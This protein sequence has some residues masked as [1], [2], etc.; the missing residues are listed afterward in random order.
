MDFSEELRNILKKYIKNYNYDSLIE[1]INNGKTENMNEKELYE[2]ISLTTIS[3]VGK[4]PDFD[5]VASYYLLKKLYLNINIYD[6]KIVLDEII[7][8]SV[9]SEKYINYCMENMNFINSILNFDNDY[10]INYFGLKTLEN[11]YLLKSKTGSI[12]ETPQ[13]LFL[14]VS[15]GI[16]LEKINNENIKKSYDVFS[17]LYYTHATPTLYNSGSK[18][19]QLSSCYLM[20]CGDSIDEISKTWADIAK[21][22]KWAGGIGINISD[23][24][25]YGSKIK[26]NNGHSDGIIPL[27]K[28]IESIGKY[29][30]QCFSPETMV[31]GLFGVK[32]I[33]N[34]EIG[35]YV[36]TIDSSFK[37]VNNIYKKNINKEILKISTIYS[38]EEIL[39]TKE[40][41]IYAFNEDD[42]IPCY[43]SANE[44]TSSHKLCYCICDN[45]YSD[46]DDMIEYYKFYGTIYANGDI[47]E[48]ENTILIIYKEFMPIIM[49][50][51]NFLIKE[52]INYSLIGYTFNIVLS[53]I[54]KKYLRRIYNSGNCKYIDTEFFN[55]SKRDTKE[56]LNGIFESSDKYFIT[57]NRIL[58]YQIAYL[59]LKYN[60]PRRCIKEN[61]LYK[62]ECICNKSLY[63][64]YEHEDDEELNLLFE[65]KI[66]FDIENIDLIDYNG[67][68]YDLNIEDNHNYTT[69]LGLVHNSGKRNGSIAIYIEPWHSDIFYFCD[70][71]RITGDESMRTR[72]LFLGLWIPDMFMR[73]VQNDDYWYLMCPDTC[74]GLT[75]SYGEEFDKL[76][77]GYVKENKYIKKVKA[78]DLYQKILESQFETGMP[79]ML[80]KD[81]CNKKS[82]QK[83][84]GTIKNSNLCSE[85]LEY[86]SKDE[87]SVCNLASISLPKFIVNGE[88]DFNK[89]GEIVRLATY[90]LN[91]VIDINF[92]PI[93]ETETSNFKHRPIGLGVQGLSD[94]FQLL[95]Y[96]FDSIEASN[97]NKKIFECI[98]YNSLLE[99]NEIAKLDGHYSSFD[100]SPFSK[101]LLQF[102]LWDKNIDDLHIDNY[103]DF[104]W[105]SLI[106]N[107]KIYGTRNSLLTTVMPTASTSL[108]MGNCECIEPYTSNMYM[109]KTGKSAFLVI[110]NNLVNDLKNINLWDDMMYDKLKKNDGSIQ[111]ISEIPI[112]IRNIYKTAFEITQKTIV[113]LSIGRAPFIDHTQ[114]LNIFMP[115]PN[116]KKLSNAHFYGWKYGLKT[117]MYYLRSKPASKNKNNEDSI[118]VCKYNGKNKGECETCSA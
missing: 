87:T 88:F 86:S 81:S 3:Y 7:K 65:N 80:Y 30:N 114:S 74:R 57:E 79:Y 49:F 31:Y 56:F 67:D 44:L 54:N 34:I 35:D 101:G 78:Q 38:F 89:L 85:I 13:H 105:N 91:N 59:S 47:Y 58:A 60:Y 52:K 73:C 39:V 11:S 20:Q 118:L 83:N 75:E 82:N 110:N 106:E 103:P 25:G 66:W 14:R 12:L 22:S 17:K 61:L 70:L 40:H 41:Q 18:Y 29:V 102:H 109:R 116:Y 10:L 115:E 55:L 45:K 112:Y 93:I 100:G 19:P 62:I 84:L 68:V 9:L 95:K 23:I 2:L 48:N 94:V 69:N 99:S 117:G 76:Y 28:V 104:D 107:I 6:Y 42:G 32:R 63:E 92:Y 5:K 33:D 24:R 8:T 111:N 113:D 43:I 46:N 64:M 51:E 90:N 71:K 97:L 50:L 37:R 26:S 4:D 16:S 15:I 72:D 27:C 98:Y 53:D 77:L 21:I 108:I 36:L 1:D 96:S